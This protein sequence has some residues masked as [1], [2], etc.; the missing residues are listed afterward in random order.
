[1][2]DP[3]IET[4]FA[5]RRDVGTEEQ[6]FHEGQIR[7]QVGFDRTVRRQPV[8]TRQRTLDECLLENRADKTI[9][10]RTAQV[11]SRR[12]LEAQPG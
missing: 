3:G 1:M 8:H 5:H 10:L 2:V 11:V 4:E 7:V 6:L 12:R 9:A